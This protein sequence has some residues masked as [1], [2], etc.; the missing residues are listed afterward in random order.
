MH[1]LVVDFKLT[2]QHVHSCL[3]EQLDQ[4][5]LLFLVALELQCPTQSKNQLLVDFWSLATTISQTTK[6]VASRRLPLLGTFIQPS[7]KS[8]LREAS[9]WST[10]SSS[11]LL[12]LRIMTYSL[13][14]ATVGKCS[15]RECLLSPEGDKEHENDR[16]RVKKRGIC[17]WHIKSLP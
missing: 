11:V 16:R 1:N 3:M 10:I 2:C 6:T 13:A 9:Q 12:Y 15:T 14:I 4:R 8:F 7:P 5:E 17:A